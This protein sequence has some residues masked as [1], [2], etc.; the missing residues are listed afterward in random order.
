[1]NGLE[2]LLTAYP[3]AFRGTE[4]DVEA[5]RQ[6]MLKLCERVEG[7]LSSASRHMIV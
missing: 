2:R 6:K 5:N 3:E 4:L 1:M 7:F